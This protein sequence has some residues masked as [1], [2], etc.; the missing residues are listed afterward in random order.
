VIVGDA[1]YA[2]EYKAQLQEAARGCNVIFTGFQFGDAYR[3]FLCSSAVYIQATE[4]GGTHPAL[5]EAMA[6]G[7]AV[8]ANGTPENKEVLGDA[9]WLYPINDFSALAKLLC[10]VLNDPDERA[11]KAELAATRA[12]ERYSWDAVT[13]KYCELFRKLVLPK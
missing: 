1:P 7:S 4:V 13:E 6:V 11:K 3:E 8:I 10:E 12:K 9:G 2:Q 5:I